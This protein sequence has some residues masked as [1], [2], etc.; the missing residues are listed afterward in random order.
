MILLTGYKVDDEEVV[1]AKEIS[2]ESPQFVTIHNVDILTRNNGGLSKLRPKPLGPWIRPMYEI[3]TDVGVFIA[4]P[5]KHNLPHLHDF[6]KRRLKVW[7]QN[8]EAPGWKWLRV[9]NAP[10]GQLISLKEALKM[11]FPAK[12]SFVYKIDADDESYIGFTTRDPKARFDEHKALAGAFNK[13]TNNHYT[14]KVHLKMQLAK[15]VN[16]EVFGTFENEIAALLAEITFIKL[17][18]CSLNKT[19]GG[20]GCEFDIITDDSVAE[21]R[22]YLILDK[23]NFFDLKQKS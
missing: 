22:E 21:K 10:L 11:R 18:D 6:I 9:P 19:I 15:K 8:S 4:E 14:Q 20:E 7:T 16:F 2:I 13:D 1:N 3:T 17:Y 12:K 5:G 23:N